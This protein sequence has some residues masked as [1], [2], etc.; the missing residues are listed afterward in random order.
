VDIWTNSERQGPPILGI[1][2]GAAEVCLVL[3]SDTI[4]AQDVAS[5]RRLADS[6]NAY[7]DEVAARSHAHPPR[8]W[9]QLD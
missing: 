1:E 2:S 9:P 5:V 6:V 8:M 7:A 3:P 4:S